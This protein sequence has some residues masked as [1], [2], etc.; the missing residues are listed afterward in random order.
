MIQTYLID[1][2]N[3]KP[4]YPEEIGWNMAI[5]TILKHLNKI[6]VDVIKTDDVV[7]SASRYAFSHVLTA[8]QI[9]VLYS[10]YLDGSKLGAIKQYKNISGLALKESK[11]ECDEFFKILSIKKPKYV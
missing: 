7:H 2:L 3:P 1:M 5:I 11:E 10:F 6:E 9:N 8:D 4:L